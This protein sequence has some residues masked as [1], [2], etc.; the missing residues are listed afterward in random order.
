M[1]SCRR[2]LCAVIVAASVVFVAAPAAAAGSLEVRQAEA[3]QA[4]A[5][6][7]VLDAQLDVAVARYARAAQELAGLEA[8]IAA[9]RHE[10][11]ESRAQLSIAQQQL[12]MRAEALYKQSG[13][14]IFDVMLSTASF[15][16]LLTR[17]EY[18]RRLGRSD[19]EIV[20]AVA[21]Y[22]RSVAARQKQLTADLGRAQRVAD[23]RAGR[24]AEIESALRERRSLLVGVR[25]EVERLRAAAAARVRAASEAS[26]TPPGASGTSGGEGVWWPLIK[27]V[28][29]QNG[30]SARGLYRL[31]MAES[32]GVATAVNGPYR[33]LYQYAGS[34][35]RGDW[36]PWRASD[37]FDGAAQIRATGLAIRL[38]HGPQWWPTAYAWAF[39][40]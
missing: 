10:L 27:D 20:D 4:A 1:P 38:G 3:A 39:A 40:S 5:D 16:E 37:I 30:I 36:N 31:M 18:L 7:A 33:G 28:A 26:A 32:G 11:A 9:N 2:S 22:R 8:R 13:A 25:A 12:A 35:W 6:V 29:A 23:A 14:S 21:Q 24:R 15:E 34:T 19:A 17:T